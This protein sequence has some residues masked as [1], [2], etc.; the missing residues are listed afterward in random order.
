MAGMSVDGLVSGLDTTSLVSQLMQ[1]EA[2]G[3]S[4]LKARVS[5]ND[6]VLAA[7]RS[8]NTKVTAVRTTAADLV[9]PTTWAA[10]STAVT[11]S[12]VQAA[13]TGTAV[14]GS[15]SVD[16]TSVAR[17]HAVHS[18]ATATG[19]DAELVPAPSGAITVNGRTLTPANGSLRALVS[20]INEAADLGVTARAVQTGV[21]E[22]RLQVVAATPGAA[23][24]FA[25]GGLDTQVGVQGTDTVATVNGLR[26]TSPTTTLPEVVPGVT[27][28]VRGEGVAT[29]DVTQDPAK[30]ADAVGA[31]VTAANTVLGEISAKSAWNATAKTGGALTGNA[32]VRALSQSVLS[33]VAGAGAGALTGVQT[34]RDGNLV[35]DRA[36]FLA[37]YAAD[38]AA[39]RAAVAPADGTGLAQRLSSVADA[40]VRTSAGDEGTLVRAVQGVESRSKDLTRQIEAWDVRLEMRRTT[41]QRQFSGLEVALN[42][43]QSQSSWLSGQLSALSSSGA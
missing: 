1:V 15:W 27:L 2:I 24:S 34:T 13:A 38:P 33:A 41:L 6:T 19:L 39:V 9:K 37:A 12:A 43:L 4:Q 7:L 23:S 30:I 5:A 32:A 28:T 25:V 31:L 26:V 14:P 8:L 17:A 40:A 36:A 20:A 22:Y 10:A 42:K 21:N 35:F 11:G 16:V 29:V 18:T 3:Q